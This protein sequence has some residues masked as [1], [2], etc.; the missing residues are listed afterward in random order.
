MGNANNTWGYTI[1]VKI[2]HFADAH[3]DM[4]NFGRQD[5]E[6]GLPYR[7]M[8]FLKSLDEI[9]DTAINEKVDLVLF[10]G[11]AFKDRTPVPTI[12]REWGK[13]IMRLSHAKIPTV[14]LVGNHDLSPSI[15]RAHA[16]ESY[17]T[18]EVPFVRVVEDP[19]LLG[20][21]ELFDVPINLIAIPWIART[22]MISYVGDQFT[23]MPELNTQFEDKLDKDVWQWIEASD[24]SMPI[25]LAAHATVEGAVFGAERTVMLGG[26]LVIPKNLVNN[27]ALDY[28]ALGHLH[29]NQ[30]LNKNNHPPVIYPGSIERVDFGE[31]KDEKFFLIADVKKGKTKVDWKKLAGIRK[32]L[33]RKVLLT[34]DKNI[35]DTILKEFPKKEVLKDA[36]FRLIL[37]YPKDWES[38]I[39]ENLLREETKEAFQFHFI[40]RPQMETRGR[41]PIDI[42][43]SQL[44][45][46]ELLEILWEKNE[47]EENEKEDLILLAEKLI[48]QREDEDT[49][50]D[51]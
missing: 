27:P 15:G 34:S 35:S 8:D 38:L 16:L 26:D 41:I 50:I 36:I 2:L 44:S 7:V 32:F 40:K 28:V 42:I 17:N 12:Q 46:R 45:P 3:I 19:C 5:P 6:S 24:E 39:D 9:V 18:L 11:D 30:N 25:V 48:H 10:A 31:A 47:M 14:L 29:K 4:T 22:K 43:S 23:T 49:P 13:R 37:E 20:P 21:A 33:D 1:M 51:M